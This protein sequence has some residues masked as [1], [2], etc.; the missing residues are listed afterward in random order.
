[1]AWLVNPLKL[2]FLHFEECF[3]KTAI[4]M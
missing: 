3:Q 2:H 1:V 4:L